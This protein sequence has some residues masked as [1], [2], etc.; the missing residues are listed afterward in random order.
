MSRAYLGRFAPSPTG[1]L[2]FGSLAS[3]VISY[4]D[5]RANQGRWLV[6]VEDIDPPRE[7]PGAAAIILTQLEKHGLTWDG[8][9][10][11]QSSRLA[12]YREA[13]DSLNAQQRLY[14]CTCSR[15]DLKQ[16]HGKHG[17]ACREPWEQPATD[18]AW[19]VNIGETASIE[20][21]DCLQGHYHQNMQDDVGDF[22]LL[23]RD[24]LVAYQLAVTVDDWHQGITHVI[25][26]LDLQDSTPRQIFLQRLLGFPTPTYGHSPIA[27][28][29]A[30]DKL[31]K[32]SHAPPVRNELA[33]QNITSVLKWLRLPPPDELTNSPCAEQLFWAQQ[34]WSRQLLRG[35]TSAPAPA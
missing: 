2:H 28:N 19:R 32:Q 16:R 1:P 21:E 29:R 11:Y 18:H 27:V 25:R 5:A 13:L 20:F 17:P 24:G 7:M 33:E 26:G 10:L 8:E 6:R 22:I 30:G 14:P 15:Q 35:F 31:S 4:L 9:V 34:H 3:A 12:A 23:R